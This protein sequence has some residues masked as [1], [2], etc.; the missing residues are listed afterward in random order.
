M[1]RNRVTANDVSKAAGVSRSA[2]SRTFTPSASVSD[3][4]RQKVIRV[5]EQ[6]GY[7]PN[8]I[9]RMLIK[10]ESDIVG[11]VLGNLTNQFLSNMTASLL[12]RLQEAGLR[13]ML[14]QAASRAELNRLLPA[15]LQYQV[16]AVLVTGLTPDPE[17]ASSCRKA[18]A[19]V[20]VIN[21]ALDRGYPG[22]GV[23]TDHHMGGRLAA[24]AL[25]RCG[26]RRIAAVIGDKSMST[27]RARLRGLRER[28][29]ELGQELHAVSDGPFSHRGGF[30]AAVKLL[31]SP[32]APDALFCSG[33][34]LAFGALDAARHE[35]GL[36]VPTELGILGYDDVPIAAWPA[37]DLST[38]QQPI[39]AIVDGAVHVFE[40]LRKTPNLPDANTL[41]APILIERR[42]TRSVA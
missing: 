23:S 18:G 3:E 20:V 1:Q 2:V 25:V 32:E 39:E 16:G 4:T 19:P 14:F 22:I 28:L 38:I 40:R 9:A 24:D 42:T 10:R 8:A 26:Y 7:R 6:L 12:A 27:H 30:D 34:L 11:V 33:D 21:R 17:V 13:P 35:F 15:V 29:E 36:E 37:Y 31:S 41:I 5:A